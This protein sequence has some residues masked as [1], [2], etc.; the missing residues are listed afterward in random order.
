MDVRASCTVPCK[1]VRFFKVTHH[2]DSID[3]RRQEGLKVLL[4][5][6]TLLTGLE[7]SVCV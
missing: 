1:C 7:I 3:S 6:A 4:I 5:L 2:V